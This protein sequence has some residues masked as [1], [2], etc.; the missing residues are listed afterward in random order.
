MG[1]KISSVNVYIF[2][3]LNKNWK[4]YFVY[5][6]FYYDIFKIYMVIHILVTDKDK[7]RMKLYNKRC[8]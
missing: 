7:C 1:K 4:K 3:V 5:Y 6:C 2:M 8:L